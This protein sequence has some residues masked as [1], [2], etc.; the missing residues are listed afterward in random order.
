MTTEASLTLNLT[1]EQA[2]EALRITMGYEVWK[3]ASQ[4]DGA[5][6]SE[7]RIQALAKALAT[8]GRKTGIL[9]C[10]MPGNGKTTMM[11]SA[12]DVI[13]AADVKDRYGRDIAI[14]EYSAK[15]IAMMNRESINEYR[16]VCNRPL[17]A[18][19]DLGEEPAETMDYGNIQSPMVD[20]IEHR[21]SHRLFTMI[22]TNL[23]PKNIKEHYG[24]RVA[25][26]FDEMMNVIYFDNKSYRSQ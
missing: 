6:H 13:N 9:L 15:E 22:T 8:T 5:E 23:T 14:K 25:D 21:Y 16:A 1:T 20:L 11:R 4:Y 24:A 18:I 19:D 12:I 7:A 17:L 26:R 10:G 2:A 3:R